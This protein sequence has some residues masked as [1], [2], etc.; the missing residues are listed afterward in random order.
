MVS[1]LIVEDD[2]VNLRI[3]SKILIKKGGLEV[4]GTENV[5]EVITLAESGE[6]DVILM[7]VSLSN[8]YYQGEAIDGIAIT[9]MLKANPLTANLPI[10]LV[11]AH[12]MRGDKEKFLSESN[13]DGY[14]SKPVVDHDLF[15][16]QIKSMIISS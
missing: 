13:A 16:S 1:V 5:D 10:I 7:D 8:S 6:I 14:I 3:F 2:P 12:A 9:K 4:K 11:T 15:V